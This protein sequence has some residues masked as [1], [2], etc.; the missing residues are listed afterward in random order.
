MRL[1]QIADEV[2]VWISDHIPQKSMDIFTYPCHDLNP[3]IWVN[4]LRPRQNGRRFAEDT[5][6]RIFLNGNVRISIT[7]SLKFLPNVPINNITALV[8][9][10]AWRRSGDKPLSEPMMVRLP[11][12]C[13]T[14]PQWIK[15]AHVQLPLCT[16]CCIILS[17]V[18]NIASSIYFIWCHWRWS[19]WMRCNYV[20]TCIYAICVI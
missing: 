10:M 12:I 15:G 20:T 3:N 7:I 5:F 2:G 18:L 13:V 4:T 9:I 16:I 6:Q 14:R 1:C 8:Q 17:S 19:T 11:H